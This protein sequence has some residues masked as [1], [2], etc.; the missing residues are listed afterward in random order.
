MKRLI[1]AAVGLALVVSV[2][3]GGI[4]GGLEAALAVGLYAMRLRPAPGERSTEGADCWHGLPVE[5]LSEL[6]DRLPQ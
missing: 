1:L 2:I 3:I 6:L 5:T 4:V